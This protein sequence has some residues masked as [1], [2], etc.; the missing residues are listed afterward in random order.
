M[1]NH[2]C[3]EGRKGIREVA[4]SI[5]NI[6][7]RQAGRRDGGAFLEVPIARTIRLFLRDNGASS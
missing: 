5:R 2:P 4:S 1:G 6:R 3:P 7:K